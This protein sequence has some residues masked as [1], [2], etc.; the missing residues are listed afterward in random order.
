MSGAGSFKTDSA[1]DARPTRIDKQD[2]RSPGDASSRSKAAAP[3]SA[4]P[5]MATETAL[6]KPKAGTEAAESSDDK[7]IATQTVAAKETFAADGVRTAAKEPVVV[8]ADDNRSMQDIMYGSDSANAGSAGEAG[9]AAFAGPVDVE[10]IHRYWPQVLK[11]INEKKRARYPFFAAAKVKRIE[12]GKLV[13]AMKPAERQFI[14]NPENLGLLRNALKIASGIDIQITCETIGEQVRTVKLSDPVV[15]GDLGE[16][17]DE[18]L[19]IGDYIKKVKDVFGAKVVEDIT[20][21]D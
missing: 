15:A 21:D 17:H 11:L 10:T 13:L 16:T 14:E 6:S 12:E 3:K 19:A 20:L 18:I 8:V 7:S 5:G 2:G 9:D 1:G 4:K